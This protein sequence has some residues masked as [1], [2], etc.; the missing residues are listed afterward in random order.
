MTQ[1]AVTNS[2]KIF[3]EDRL[4]TTLVMRSLRIERLKRN[5]TVNSNQSKLIFDLI[6]KH[7]Y[8]QLKDFHKVVLIGQEN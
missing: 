8:G 4:I 2:S 5:F 3:L 7:T 1:T 6:Q